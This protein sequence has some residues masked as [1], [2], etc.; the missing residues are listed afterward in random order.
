MQVRIVLSFINATRNKKKEHTCSYD[1]PPQKRGPKRQQEGDGTAKPEK[2]PRKRR[3]KDTPSDSPINSTPP[4]SQSDIS[5]GQRNPDFF[6]ATSSANTPVF[7]IQSFNRPQQ[8]PLTQVNQIPQ[9][10]MS[11][12]QQHLQQ[13]L[14]PISFERQHVPA[15]LMNQITPPSYSHFMNEIPYK[16]SPTPQQPTIPPLMPQPT[17]RIQST[18][19][20]AQ[21]NHAM[22]SSIQNYFQQ[23]FIN[24]PIMDRRKAIAIVSYINDLQ[25]GTQTTTVTPNNDELALIFAMQGM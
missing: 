17:E 14:P 12:H 11:M 10:H 21:L 19:N 4:P 3:K 1:E 20:N 24:T 23:L 25:N 22:P 15:P 16:Q 13:T 8:S 18:S 9:H 7:Q 6:A 5:W 2:Q